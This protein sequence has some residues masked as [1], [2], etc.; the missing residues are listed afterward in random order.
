M[1]DR[2]VKVLLP[3]LPGL[4]PALVRI[5]RGG[6]P[7]GYWVRPL[8]TDFGLG[9]RLD[10]DEAAGGYDVLLEND[11]DASCTCP[12]HTYRGRCKHVDALRALLAAG[13]LEL[14][15]VAHGP[16]APAAAVPADGRAA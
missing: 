2:T 1:T 16:L 10:R 12:G 14:P 8:A 11:Q 15:A 7:Q 9:Y 3:A 13:L 4:A 5:T 6:V